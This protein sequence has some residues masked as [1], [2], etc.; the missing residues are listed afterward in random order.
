MGTEGGDF[1]VG[2]VEVACG[3]RQGMGG[4]GCGWALGGGRKSEGGF[5]PGGSPIDRDF[6]Q[7][8][9]ALQQRGRTEATWLVGGGFEASRSWV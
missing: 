9:T 7:D 1:V 8:F 4:G 2:R 5:V 3:S 6:A